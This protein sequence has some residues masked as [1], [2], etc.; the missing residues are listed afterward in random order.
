MLMNNN[1]ANDLTATIERKEGRFYILRLT[2]QQELKVPIHCLDRQVKAGETIHL[3]FLTDQQF[4]AT[5]N[6]LAQQILESILNG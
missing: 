1:Q 4:S 3:Q 2:D 5:K 6:E